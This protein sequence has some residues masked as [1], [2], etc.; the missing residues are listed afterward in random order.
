MAY[1]CVNDSRK[2][3]DC[4]YECVGGG[5]EVVPECVVCGS[6]KCDYFYFN[7]EGEPIGCDDC[8][9]REEVE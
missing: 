7:K 1:L 5:E 3:C 4:C 9:R 8:I 2:E 6:T